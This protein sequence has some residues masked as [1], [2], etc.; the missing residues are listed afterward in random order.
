[1]WGRDF[2]MGPDIASARQNLSLIIDNG[3]PAPDL[4]TGGSAKWG[5]TLGNKLLVWRSGVGVTANGALVYAG[6]NNLSATT[7]AGVLV[8]AGAVRAME[9]DI[10]SEW[11]DYFTYGPPAPTQAPTSLS[12]TKLL[13]E[14]RASADRYLTDN[15]RDFIAIFRRQP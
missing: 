11:V 4:A 9:L 1:M 5:A 15:S 12:A 13:P 8:R 3:V 7:L 6:G 14:M 2:Q 10:N